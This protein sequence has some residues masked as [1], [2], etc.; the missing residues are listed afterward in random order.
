MH[1][2]PAGPPPPYRRLADLTAFRLGRAVLGYL[3]AVIVVI[4]LAPFQFAAHPMH[5][6]TS[7]WEWSDIIMNIVMFVPVGFVYQLTRPAGARVPWWRVVVLGA[8]LS[9]AVEF[10]Q[11]F[12]ATR[13]TSLVDLAT[14]TLGAVVGAWIYGVLLKRLDG[15]STVRSLAL[16]LPLTGLVYLLVPLAWLV[17]L[18][19][20]TGV[21]GGADARGWLVLLI[22]VFGSGVIGAVFTAYI[23]PS[24][25]L[26]PGRT[27]LA[28]ALTAGGWSAV[29]LL[30]S[31]LRDHALLVAG[32]AIAI[33]IA[34]LRHL[35]TM[36]VQQ[37]TSARFEL[38]TLRLVLPFFAAFLALS[39]LWPL[40]SAQPQWQWMWALL[41]PGDL[42]DRAI[43]LALEHVASFTL[44]GYIIA[45]FYGRDLER[46]RQIAGRVLLWGGGISILLEIARGF[47]PAVR[48]SVTMIS[49]TVI[50]AM[51]GG[52]LYQLQR[53]HVR[54]LL[55]RTRP[56]PDRRG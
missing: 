49:C 31:G 35:A 13:F 5:G 4:T 36:R 18:S 53:D 11:L 39:S 34:W 44:V 2:S 27:R 9:G 43:F 30:I 15:T 29:A 23:A 40:D 3:A 12:E 21:D 7:L 46:Y 48:A 52:R 24:R 6:I 41:P 33:G 20:G 42:T 37:S 17:G 50:A 14:N 8:G 47:E 1:A 38:P 22:V 51:F 55:A 56:H 54:A 45:E 32:I 28:I 25:Q 26:S 10:G 16:E 19:S